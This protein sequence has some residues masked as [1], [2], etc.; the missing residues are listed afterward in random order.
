MLLFHEIEFITSLTQLFALLYELGATIDEQVDLLIKNY[1]DYWEC[2][3]CGKTAKTRQ[4][5]KYH[6]ESHLGIQLSCSFCGKLFRTTHSLNNHVS[7]FH[8]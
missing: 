3:E 6:A 8:K 5:I 7:K 1:G 2:S 4:H